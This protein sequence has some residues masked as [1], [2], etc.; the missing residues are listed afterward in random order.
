[1]TCNKKVKLKI[2]LNYKL[3]LNQMITNTLKEIVNNF[4]DEVITNMPCDRDL[5][6]KVWN[7]INPDLM[8]G[9]LIVLQENR[10][11]IYRFNLQL[12]R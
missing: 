11:C 8:I 2:N 4:F 1:M 10:K 7:E 12:Q 5:L 9:N 6:V 3:I